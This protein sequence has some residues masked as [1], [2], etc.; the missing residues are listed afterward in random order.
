ME[1]C[2][3]S[4]VICKIATRRD[5]KP[6]LRH[7]SV[8]RA[9]TQWRH[10]R[11]NKGSSITHTTEDEDHRD[12][13]AT[14]YVTNMGGV[15]LRMHYTDDVND[16]VSIATNTTALAEFRTRRRLVTNVCSTQMPGGRQ[17]ISCGFEAYP[18]HKCLLSWTC[19]KRFRGKICRLSNPQY[20][21]NR[22]L[23]KT[24]WQTTSLEN[25]RKKKSVRRKWL[26]ATCRKH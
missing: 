2:Q 1:Y 21:R 6:R 26:R 20:L 19:R 15:P 18:A 3:L 10:V 13:T 22:L 24:C 16:T 17:T 14:P 25:I 9:F 12:C 5:L 8:L 4:S 11:K 7:R 23:T